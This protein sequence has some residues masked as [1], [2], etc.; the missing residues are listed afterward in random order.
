MSQYDL[1]AYTN[2]RPDARLMLTVDRQGQELVI[3]VT[4]YS[5]ERQVLRV[6]DKGRIVTPYALIGRIGL[7]L[8]APTNPV[9]FRRACRIGAQASIQA[10]AVVID[11]LQAMISGKIRATPGG[12]V[13]ILAMSYE[14]A[15]LGWGQ[16]AT[17]GA[18]LSANLAVLNLLPIPP[19]DGF[20]LLVL[21]FEALIRRRIDARAEYLVK[22][23]G[24][25]MLM[26]LLVVLTFNDVRNLILHGP[27]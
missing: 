14:S 17:F 12:P 19:L 24:F 11:S 25:L 26:S 22:V 7:K 8:Q 1:V 4:T 27:P 21:A 2:L 5:L 9:S 10:V 13:S 16:V 20:V 23:A 18:F 3:P 6:D 15:K